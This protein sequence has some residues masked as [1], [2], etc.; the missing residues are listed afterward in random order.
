MRDTPLFAAGSLRRCLF[1]LI[2]IQLA[3]LLFSGGASGTVSMTVL[4][5]ENSTMLSIRVPYETIVQKG[6]EV[7]IPFNITNIGNIP[8][9][10]ISLSA[11]CELPCDYYFAASVLAPNQSISSKI[12]ISV[13][14]NLQPGAKKFILHARDAEGGN[15][16]A[17]FL[18]IAKSCGDGFCTSPYEDC[19]NCLLDCGC[20]WGE[21]CAQGQCNINCAQDGECNPRC[22][23]DSD[24]D[25]ISIGQKQGCEYMN[26]VCGECLDCVSY[27]C[28]AINASYQISAPLEAEVGSSVQA[29]I[30]R[31]DG[32]P[33][34]GKKI[35]VSH[36]SGSSYSLISSPSGRIIFQ[37][38]SEGYYS[39]SLA[40]P[41]A[42]ERISKTS[43]VSAYVPSSEPSRKQLILPF[44]VSEPS[45]VRVQ[46]VSLGKPQQAALDF[47][48]PNDV[49]SGGTTGSEGQYSEYLSLPGKY[50]LT[51]SAE[52]VRSL[53]AKVELS[54]GA[55]PSFWSLYL[56]PAYIIPALLV[57]VALL[58]VFMFRSS[59]FRLLPGAEKKI[60]LEGKLRAKYKYRAEA[61][62]S[63]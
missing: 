37:A 46:V 51:V 41:C 14:S 35:K 23:A 54:P 12:K 48:G 53:S 25:K 39:F 24:C 60:Q 4:S 18:L 5:G 43:T 47:L 40:S 1:L 7:S 19:S 6:S 28:V 58:V 3:G 32:T 52:N 38:D 13:P 9:S 20:F 42:A 62:K 33:V 50:V 63:E 45:E 49:H 31:S 59:I 10:N 11:E 15:W 55:Q 44:Y 17:E 16:E 29:I 8:I 34:S 2:L 36:S 61:K 27:S 21:E 57:A 56:N 26:P 30:T 22:A